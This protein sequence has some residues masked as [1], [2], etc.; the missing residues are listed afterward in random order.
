MTYPADKALGPIGIRVL[1]ENDAVR[2]W[3]VEVEPGDKQPM[4]RHF[5]PYVIVPLTGVPDGKFNPRALEMLARSYVELKLFDQKPE[6]A[7]LYTD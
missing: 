5:L 7:K 3:A 6:M 1:F 4:H 2:V